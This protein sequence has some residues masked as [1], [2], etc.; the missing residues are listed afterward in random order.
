VRLTVVGGRRG[1]HDASDGGKDD[2]GTHL[3]LG[4]WLLVVRVIRY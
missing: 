4:E 3:D 1:G 2:G